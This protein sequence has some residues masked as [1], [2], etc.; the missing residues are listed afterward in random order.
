MGLDT[1][2]IL[3][4]VPVLHAQR[5]TGQDGINRT[6]R[7][8]AGA[9]GRPDAEVAR[10]IGVHEMTLGKWVKVV[11]LENRILACDLCDLR[12]QAARSYSLIR[13]LRTGFRR[14]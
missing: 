12:C 8:Y 11:P 10:N 14:I 13:P 4:T 5:R 7:H 6:L 2:M 3:E 9:L 1:H